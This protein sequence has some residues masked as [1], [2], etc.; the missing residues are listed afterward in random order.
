MVNEKLKTSFGKLSETY[1][2]V[3]PD[4]PEEL[5]NDVIEISGIPPDG[6]ILEIGT[7]TGKATKQF[8]EKGYEMT[9]LDISEE[10]LAIARKNLSQFSK[11][12]YIVSPFERADLPANIFE[13]VFAAQAFHW[14]D[15]EIGYK[16]ASEVLKENGYLAFFSN[17]QARNAELEQQI[18]KLYTKHC[19]DYPG[20]VE[21]GTLRTLQ[22]QFKGSGLFGNVKRIT[23]MRDIK[24]TKEKYLGLLGSFSFISTLPQD[25]KIQFFR[26]LRKILGDKKTIFV[27]TESI[28]LIAK[29]K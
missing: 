19:L 28:L 4:Y 9:A 2:E 10:Q 5:I 17:F 26:E 1:D 23:Y 18:R 13:L 25:K 12:K 24:Y 27:P 8:A 16:K 14:V 22:K 7:G 6:K 21:F 29:K 3:R 11:I 15:P 20:K